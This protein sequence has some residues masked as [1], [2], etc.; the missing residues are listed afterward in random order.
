MLNFVSIKT[1]EVQ[2][3]GT[4]PLEL[5]QNHQRRALSIS[6]VWAYFYLAFTLSRAGSLIG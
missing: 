3:V 6:A 2:V 1:G 4:Y 5:H